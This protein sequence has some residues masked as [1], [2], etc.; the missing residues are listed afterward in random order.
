[1]AVLNAEMTAALEQLA[2]DL[3]SPVGQVPFERVA[4]R[5]SKLLDSLRDLGLTWPQIGLLLHRYGIAREDGSPLS[6]TQLSSVASRQKRATQPSSARK[7][8][9]YAGSSSGVSSGRE[10]PNNPKPT[11]RR[12]P[13][14][15]VARTSTPPGMVSSS[16]LMDRDAIRATLA[17]EKALRDRTSQS[18]D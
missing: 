8:A 2:A 7:G 10:S 3:T 6:G 18:D 15:A 12:R 13:E 5:Y 16:T 14:P 1:M 4:R 11:G 17:H 9:P